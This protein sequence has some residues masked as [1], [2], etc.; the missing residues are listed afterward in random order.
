AE[1]GA[2]ASVVTSS[3]AVA[4]LMDAMRDAPAALAAL[5]A[6]PALASHPRIAERLRVSGFGDVRLCA[7]NAAA[8]QAAVDA[9]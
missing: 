5:R 3:E 6:G 2:V 7:P 9:T 4:A 1:Q 8:I